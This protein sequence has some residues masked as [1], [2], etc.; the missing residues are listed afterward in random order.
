MPCTAVINAADA[1]VTPERGVLR[2][3]LLGIGKMLLAFVETSLTGCVFSI[4]DILFA[5]IAINYWVMDGMRMDFGFLDI[6]NNIS[7]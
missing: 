7:R 5:G 6:N 4:R 2:S 1:V 3:V